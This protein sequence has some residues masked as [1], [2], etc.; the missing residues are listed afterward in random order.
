MPAQ[1]T[2]IAIKLPV[3]AERPVM[4][5]QNW[6]DVRLTESDGA[7]FC[8]TYGYTKAEAAARAAIIVAAFNR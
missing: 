4:L 1:K 6:W 3:R 7:V 5:S 2:N 8:K